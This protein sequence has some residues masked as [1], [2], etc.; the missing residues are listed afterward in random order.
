[1]A[2]CMRRD[3][4]DR[5]RSRKILPLSGLNRELKQHCIQLVEE[6][7]STTEA[8]LQLLV[9]IPAIIP[10][11]CLPSQSLSTMTQHMR[12]GGSGEDSES[13][14]CV[15]TEV[16][17]PLSDTVFRKFPNHRVLAFL[18]GNASQW[19][20]IPARHSDAESRSCEGR[21]D[22]SCCSSTAACLSACARSERDIWY[23]G[24][25]VRYSRTA[26][27]GCLSSFHEPC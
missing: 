9:C 8:A 1:M 25:P 23:S 16:P 22:A 17:P 6:S 14:G 13:D 18:L 24:L 26:T 3:P 20:S 5:P 12:P 11:R 7:S 2:G 4:D 15:R 10:L 19:D 21:V 27:P